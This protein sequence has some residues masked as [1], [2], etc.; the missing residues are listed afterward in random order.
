MAE[1]NDTG[2]RIKLESYTKQELIWLI[3][4]MCTYRLSDQDLRRA[5]DELQFDREMKHIDQAQKELNRSIDA[6]R[7]YTEL[8][9]PYNGVRLIDIPVE[10]LKK[11]DAAVKESRVAD[12]RW[13]K[14]MGIE[15]NE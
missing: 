13:R 5:V 1:K 14:L 9:A 2:K 8:L 6:Q 11:A 3:R 12:K 15:E 10:I 7:R 4:E